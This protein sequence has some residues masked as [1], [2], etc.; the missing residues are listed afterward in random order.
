MT[1]MS[2]SQIPIRQKGQSLLLRWSWRELWQGQLWPVAVALTLIIACV[3]AL[4]SLVVR[5]EKIM[6]S[7]GRS[8]IAADLVLRSANPVSET[9]LQEARQLGLTVTQQTSFGTM[10]FSDQAMQLVSVKSVASDFPLRGELVLR[11]GSQT[12][13]QV[14]PGELWL[15]ERLFSLLEVKTGDSVAIGNAE[16]TVSGAIVSEPELSFNP[17][18]QMPAVLI[19]ESDLAATEAIQ[20][21]SRVRYRAYFNGD[22]ALLK[23]L[24]AD[25][26]LSPDQRWIS[27]TTQGRTG[28]MIERVQQYLSLTLILVILMATATL[29]LTCMHYTASRTETVAMMKSLGARKSFLW[30]WL[31]RQ[32]GLLFVIAAVAGL[33]LGGILEWLLRLPLRDVLPE[34]LPDMGVMPWIVSL[35]VA[36]LVAIPGM[37]ITL[38]RL[39][40]APAL[41]VM[42]KGMLATTSAA[43]YLLVLIPLTALLLWVGDNPMM[44][45]TL[46]G[47]IGLLGVLAGL[48]LLLVAGLRRRRW[49]AAMT[50][51]LSRIGRSP[52][53]TGAQL[54][55]LTSSLMLLAVIWLL[56]TDLLE[57]WQQ[58]LPPDAPN[59]FALNISPTEQQAYLD[60]L[61]RNGLMRSDS[62][63][64]VRGRLVSINGVNP[65][66]ETT[67]TE[68]QQDERQEGDESLRR[69]LNFTWRETIPVH[70]TLVAGEW[71]LAPGGVSVETGVAERLGI[72][73]GDTLGFTVNSQ[74]FSATVTS[75]R[76]VEWRNMRPNFFFI[77]TPDVMVNLPATWLVSFRVAADQSE[78]VNQLGR[79]YPTVTLLDLRTMATRIQ[80]ILQ[81]VSLSL[82]VLAMLGVCSGLLLVLTL[83]RL[84]LS[85]RQQE[86][87]LYRTL[88]ASRQRI[89]ATIWS[90]YGLMAVL[91][92][93]IAVFGAEALVA[94]LI[95]WGFE[96][97]VTW[98][99]GL[100]LVLPLLSVLLILLI[101][102]SMMKQLLRPLGR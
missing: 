65:R 80:A 48:G 90:E 68:V 49:G 17:F 93:G 62:Y 71:H 42:Q 23:Q 18:S 99:P 19:H 83:L 91:A 12:Q 44:W 15:S 6:I 79:D 2:E 5:V 92:G 26:V 45:L 75:L 54:A 11:G 61:D 53:V 82:S 30:R 89:R 66:A 81:Q 27:E 39:L 74:P 84:S 50:L 102:S 70:N 16:L 31:A 25:V 10:A 63:P 32:L 78:L 29:V 46:A 34:P 38:W 43:R 4:A 57:D 60:V 100:W 73:L 72:K 36:V 47:L 55:A 22:D 37:G 13:Q 67:A 59:V 64:I 40:D 88:G 1:E 21:G 77:F 96:L 87:K 76:E 69:E 33:S 95:K 58:T 7:Q 101:I 97:P 51:A 41:A 52:L 94:A 28:E 98:H 56:R 24:Q 35:L 85:Q 20:P 3:F 86:I 8:M 14:K 9:V